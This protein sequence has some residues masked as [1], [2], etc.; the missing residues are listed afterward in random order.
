MSTRPYNSIRRREQAEAR[1]LAI[2][3]AAQ[4]LFE[5]NGYAATTIGAIA[6]AA[7]VS[8]K[9]VH[10]AFETKSGVLRAVWHRALRG[11]RDEVPIPGQD[12]YA[13]VMAATDP[14]EIVRLVALNSRIIKERA[15]ALMEVLRRSDE[16]DV[17]ELWTRI[18]TE[19]HA[20]QRR[21]TARLDELG[22]LRPGLTSE[23][24]GDVLWALNHPD[25]WQQLVV[26]RGWTPAEYE[27]WLADAL[28]AQ[29]LS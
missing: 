8:A 10:L 18:Q 21:I 24:A 7:G 15:A 19:F 23:R 26:W 27:H 11:E 17:A 16:P 6:R 14:E 20:I 1:R 13:A 25:V 2:L 5:A 9:T 22:A 29:L 3:A 4:T 12:W 28:H